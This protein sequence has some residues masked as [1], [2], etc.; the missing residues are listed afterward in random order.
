MRWE[1][2]DIVYKCNR[3]WEDLEA[4]RA[5][6]KWSAV[7]LV[8]QVFE[9]DGASGLTA[10]EVWELVAMYRLFAIATI[11]AVL[12]RQTGLFTLEDGRW[13]LTGDS[14]FQF[15]SA[16]SSR[17]APQGSRLD[18][19]ARARRRAR[20][21]AE[22]LASI[23]NELGDETLR[24]ELA[25]LIGLQAIGSGIQDGFERGCDDFARSGE[26]DL[27]DALKREILRY[28]ELS[29]LAVRRLEEASTEELLRG[30]RLLQVICNGGVP[31]AVTRA[32]VLRRQLATLASLD[33]PDDLLVAAEVVIRQ[34]AE[35][36]LPRGA[37][38]SG[39]VSAYAGLADL[40]AFEDPREVGRVLRGLE[41][42]SRRDTSKATEDVAVMASRSV[43]FAKVASEIGDTD[44]HPEPSRQEL[45]IVSRLLG[46]G[47]PATVIAAL[48]E[49]GKFLARDS[50]RHADAK[51]VFV[52]ATAYARAVGTKGTNVTF[53]SRSSAKLESGEVSPDVQLFLQSWCELARIVSPTEA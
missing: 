15:T 23:L 16:S 1:T 52:V 38:V 26:L 14:V 31:E 17:P 50:L 35:G 33:R 29:L 28:P 44:F 48:N 36:S 20:Q 21:L 45:L 12:A 4:L 49:Y 39:F 19:S 34:S 27:C 43:A 9:A 32:Q 25:A 11:R 13:Y 51:A 53:A 7:N 3:R 41:L 37:V 30:E 22:D 8:I 47:E 42:L 46:G 10:E 18:G 2:V 24:L 6:A 40:D 5:E